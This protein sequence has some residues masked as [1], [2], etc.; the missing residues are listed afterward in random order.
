MTCR[1]PGQYRLLTILRDLLGD[2]DLLPTAH[3]IPGVSARTRILSQR[4]AVLLCRCR[5]LNLKVGI[6]AGLQEY[7]SVKGEPT[8]EAVAITGQG[9]FDTLKEVAKLAWPSSRKTPKKVLNKSAFC[10]PGLKP[11]SIYNSLDAGLK[12]GST[13]TST[14][15]E[16]P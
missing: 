13:R 12:A 11:R 15:S 3:T 10:F 4:L 8:C 16:F 1:P 5:S 7:P 2:L 6:G 9:V 14:C